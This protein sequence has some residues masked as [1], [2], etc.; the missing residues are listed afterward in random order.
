MHRNEP[1]I[2]PAFLVLAALLLLPAAAAQPADDPD[3]GN[4]E[5]EHVILENTSEADLMVRTGSINNVGFG[6]GEDENPFAGNTT[7][8][9]SYPWEAPE[10]AAPGTD[11]IMLGTNYSGETRDGYSR[12]WREDSEETAPRDIV[13]E[14]DPPSFEVSRAVLQLAVDDFQ[15]A[16]FGSNFTVTLN[17]REA[18]FISDIINELDQ[19]GPIAQVITTEVPE[20]FLEE[21]RSG[22]VALFFDETTGIGDGYALDFVK[23]LINHEPLQFTGTITGTVTDD[24]GR[25]GGG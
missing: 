23:L 13:L 18:P 10:D 17:G 1:S 7:W 6:F 4:W 11:R 16:A 22:R 9:H 12:T 20:D 14:Y 8:N 25:P 15:A 5:A 3:N 21:I 19:T 24:E 2:F